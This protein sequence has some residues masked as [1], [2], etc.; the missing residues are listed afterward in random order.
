MR[1]HSHLHLEPLQELVH[2]QALTLD[3]SPACME[4]FECCMFNE[5]QIRA[6]ARLARL[7]RLTLRECEYAEDMDEDDPMG[8][9][10]LRWLCPLP[11][12]LQQL[13]TLDFSH[14]YLHLEHMQLLQRLPSLTALE[15][16]VMYD[17]AL[18]LLPSFAA[19]LQRLERDWRS[20]LHRLLDISRMRIGRRRE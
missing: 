15:P 17:S 4:G 20:C 6:V 9:R 10:W 2:L 8:T 5:Q 1:P 11:H 12:K 3:T 19:R 13:Q 18:P 7:R 14:F 16:S